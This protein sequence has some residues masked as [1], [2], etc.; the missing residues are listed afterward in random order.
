MDFKVLFKYLDYEIWVT[1]SQMYKKPLVKGYAKITLFFNN[2][3]II[4]LFFFGMFDKNCPLINVKKLQPKDFA[5]IEPHYL[6]T[7]FVISLFPFRI[8]D[9]STNAQSGCIVWFKNMNLV[10]VLQG[11]FIVIQHVFDRSTI[12]QNGC[13]A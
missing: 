10:K 9:T 11:S 12:A 8:I 4:G 6:Q 1:P 3:Q 13:I 5:N 2:M 7:P